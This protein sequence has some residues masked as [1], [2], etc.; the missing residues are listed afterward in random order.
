MKSGAK[1]PILILALDGA[2]EAAP[3]QTSRSFC[4]DPRP[5]RFSKISGIM[6]LA[7]FSLQGLQREG[8]RCQAHPNRGFYGLAGAVQS[9]PHAPSVLRSVCFNHH[10]GDRGVGASAGI[11]GE[12]W[13]KRECC[14]G[15]SFKFAQRQFPILSQ[16]A[17]K[18]GPP[19]DCSDSN[20]V[21]LTLL[22][23][24]IK[25]CVLRRLSPVRPLPLESDE[26]TTRPKQSG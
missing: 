4:G 13:K 15:N 3:F 16:E 10:E 21:L 25:L 22:A 14:R 9:E 12:L 18:D 26:K 1:T 6:D 8:L 20:R 2:A 23:G 7:E 19:A 24:A 5:P 17:R 11:T